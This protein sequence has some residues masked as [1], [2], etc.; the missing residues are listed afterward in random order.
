MYSI[1]GGDGRVYG[2]ATPDEIRR[3]IREGRADSRTKVK[4]QHEANWRDLGSLEDFYPKSV[5]AASRQLVESGPSRIEIA[6]GLKPVACLATAWRAYQGDPWKIT[7]VVVLGF[8]AL[9][10]MGLVPFAGA[11][12]GLVLNGPVMGALY[13]FSRQSLLQRPS[14]LEGCFA[15]M[16]D[17]FLPLFLAH[18]VSQ[19]LA[20]LPLVIS[21]IP[22]LAMAI[23]LAPAGASG[24]GHPLIT[25]LT[26]L[27]LG[28]GFLAT[29]Y[30]G[31][32]WSMAVPLAACTSLDFWKAIKTSW[33]GVRSNFMAFLGL[34]LLLGL[35]NIVGFLFLIVG[36]FVTMP[37][38]M[39][40][41]MAA[42][43][44]V[45][46]PGSATAR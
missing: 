6:V 19:V 24:D 21:L 22:S 7:G 32:V 27:P 14:N 46:Q 26:L 8:L 43:N 39:L 1:L 23:G 34:F 17:R 44:H 35:F 42:Y 20:S 40:A 5:S 28:V 11:G 10:L 18:L 3:W 37:L 16:L 25:F 41:L 13:Y 4:L 38:T 2:P 15:L 30:L 36:S 12:V 31:L 29:L 45:F 9:L 33:R